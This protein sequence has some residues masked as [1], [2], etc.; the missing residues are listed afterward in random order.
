MIKQTMWLSLEDLKCDAFTVNG[1]MGNDVLAL[2]HDLK[3][4]P[5]A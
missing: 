2:E 3:F 4:Q 1:Y 5:S